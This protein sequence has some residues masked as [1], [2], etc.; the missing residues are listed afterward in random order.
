MNEFVA[1]THAVAGRLDFGIYAVCVDRLFVSANIPLAVKYLLFGEILGY[2]PLVRKELLTNLLA[3]PNAP[4]ELVLYARE[5][6]G[7]AL[8]HDQLKE[9]FLFATLKMAWQAQEALAAR[10]SAIG[11]IRQ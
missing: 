7:G 10:K 5:R 8:T 4:H 3:S 9:T 1:F 2:P 11:E 6:I